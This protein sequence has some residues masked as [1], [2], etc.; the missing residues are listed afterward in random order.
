MDKIYE[1]LLRFKAIVDNQECL[2]DEVNRCTVHMD[3]ITA[4][5]ALE[6]YNKKDAVREIECTSA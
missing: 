1:A 2:C 6:N 5:M 3:R 4:D